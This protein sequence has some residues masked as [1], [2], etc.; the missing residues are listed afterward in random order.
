MDTALSCASDS[1]FVN[2]G[3]TCIAPT[4]L[5]VQSGIYDKFVKKFVELASKV[6]VGDAFAP[7]SFQGPQVD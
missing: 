4:R 1:L 5:F 7:D 3:Q 2:A 6:K